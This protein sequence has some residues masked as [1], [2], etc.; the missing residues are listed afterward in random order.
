MDRRALDGPTARVKMPTPHI[1][2]SV[3]PEQATCCAG[4]NQFSTLRSGFEAGV[5]SEPVLAACDSVPQAP[6]DGECHAHDQQDNSQRPQNRYIDEK[7][8]NEQNDS[9]Y[10]Q[11]NSLGKE[12]TA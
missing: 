2:L 8:D 11:N 10:D 1:A 5:P 3:L 12:V 9:E 4:R 6:R 7:T